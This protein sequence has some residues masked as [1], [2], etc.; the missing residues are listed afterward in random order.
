MANEPA[1]KRPPGR[2]SKGART[3]GIS[4]TQETVDSLDAIKAITGDSHA[5][6]VARGIA[7]ERKRVERAAR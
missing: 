2:P 5:A 4:M 1:E 6:I 7:A 3:V